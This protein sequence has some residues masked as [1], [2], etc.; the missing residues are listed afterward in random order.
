MVKINLVKCH[1][2]EDI[3]VCLIFIL[4]FALFYDYSGN[5]CSFF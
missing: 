5:A 1:R 4:M 3:I 2:S